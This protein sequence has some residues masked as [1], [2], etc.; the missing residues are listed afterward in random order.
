[1]TEART[2][3]LAAVLNR[4]S[5]RFNLSAPQLVEAALRRGEGRLSS[6]GAFS[7]TTGKYTGRSPNDKFIV[8]D[9][10][11]RDTVAWGKVNVPFS[12]EKFHK[13]YDL[14]LDFLE[15]RDELFVFDGYVGAHPDHSMPL[16][17]INQYAWQNLFARQLFIRPPREAL[18]GHEPQFTVIAV[19]GLQAVPER[20]GTNSEAFVIVSF[21]ERV[22]LIGGT[23]YAG[24]IKKS[25]FT[26]MNYLL[27]RDGVLSMHCSANVGADGRTALFFGLSGTGKTTLSADPQRRLVGDDEHGWSEGG[28]FNL[29][30][31]CYAKCINLSREHEP[32]IWDAIRFGAVL[33]NVVLDPHEH[34]ADYADGS[35]TENTR[36]AYPLDYI[37]G[38]VDPSIAGHP[39]AVVFL[40]ADAFGVLPPIS[41]LEDEQ[42]M[43]HFISGYTS[44]LAGTERGIKEPEATFS[45]CFGEPFLPLS[46]LKYAEMLK[47]RV[48]K[49]GAKVFLINTGW[50]GGPYG[51]G[52]RIS[53][54]HTR[55]MVTAA[56]SGELDH[57]ETRLDP[58]FGF[59]VPVSCPDVP[60]EILD[61]KKT[62]DD[63]AAYDAKARELAKAFQANFQA[64]YA[65]L[66][67]EVRAAGPRLD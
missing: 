17:V 61:P 42:I 38:R 39:T 49:H 32:Q 10:V 62:W 13:I 20:D 24:E 16:R 35:L 64:K 55:R 44:K 9:E 18:Q 40:T 28:I 29:E 3:R 67:P 51:V 26:V 41:I 21:K 11:T 19:P 66:A 1:M 43:Y 6:T 23:A 53:L 46:P 7:T 47:E 25:I 22:V 54:K 45:A 34:I 12:E 33:E 63:P 31:G 27:P 65:G 56:L 52:Q 4:P 14:V 36:C 60:S 8:E 48:N 37:P 30:G 57:V 15:Q 58:I 5:T 2:S 50:S 59:K